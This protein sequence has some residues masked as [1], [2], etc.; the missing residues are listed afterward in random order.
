MRS[1]MSRPIHWTTEVQSGTGRAVA[2]IPTGQWYRGVLYRAAMPATQL[3]PY[4][5]M[6]DLSNPAGTARGR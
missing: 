2:V 4:H 1:Q 5:H 3:P 6:V